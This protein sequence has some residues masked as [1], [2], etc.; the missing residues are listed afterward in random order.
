M[1]KKQAEAKANQLFNKHGNY[2]QFDIMDLGKISRAAENVL[3]NG[4]DM[5]EAEAALIEAIDI[6][7]VK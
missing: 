7:E 5:D 3:M 1:N 6:Y 2:K 4:G